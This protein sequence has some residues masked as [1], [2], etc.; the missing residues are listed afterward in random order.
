MDLQNRAY[1]T[2][3]LALLVPDN[4]GFPL[5]ILDLDTGKDKANILK[6]GQI[7]SIRNITKKLI[8]VFCE[9]L[10][11]VESD[12][13]KFNNGKTLHIISSC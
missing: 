5:F 9:L 13:K 11:E 10:L 8:E 3:H 12:T 1:G 4:D 7:K 2:D 6:P